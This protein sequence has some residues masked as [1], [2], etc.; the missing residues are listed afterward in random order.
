MDSPMFP[1]DFI[2]LSKPA[3]TMYYV[4]NN[5]TGTPV[6]R[7]PS[8]SSLPYT[9]DNVLYWVPNDTTLWKKTTGDNNTR[10]FFSVRLGGVC[11]AQMTTFAGTIGL[12]NSGFH[13]NVQNTFP[14]TM[15]MI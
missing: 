2:V 9:F 7:A 12:T 10:T 13:L 8:I 4:S 11:S 5:C 3:P 15:T 1:E 6:L 14:W